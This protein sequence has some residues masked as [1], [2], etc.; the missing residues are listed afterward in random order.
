M[1]IDTERLEDILKEFFINAFKEY[2]SGEF[3]MIEKELEELNFD[4]TPWFRDY[5]KQ[6]AEDIGEIIIEELL[7]PKDKEER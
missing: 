4:S 6:E 7:T 1:K 2:S 5:I 3:S